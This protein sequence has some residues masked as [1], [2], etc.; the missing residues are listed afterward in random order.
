MTSPHRTPKRGGTLFLTIIGASLLLG[1]LMSA[2]FSTAKLSSQYA[3]TGS[4]EIEARYAA[5]AAIQRAFGELARDPDWRSG[6]TARTKLVQNPELTYTLEVR[7]N[8]FGTPL[9]ENE[10][11]LYAQGYSLDAIEPVPLAALAGTAVRP[12]G[13]FGEA[14]FGFAGLTMK[15]DSVS[16]AFDSRIG[17]HWYNPGEDDDDR[18]TLVADAGHVG[19]AKLV[20]L[21]DSKVEGDIVLPDPSSFQL[22]ST[23]YSG[24]AEVVLSGSGEF[25]GEEQRPKRRRE[26]PKTVSPYPEHTATTSV[27]DI[28]A[29]DVEEGHHTLAPGPYNRLEVRQ[30]QTLRLTSGAYFFHELDLRGA[31]LVLDRSSGPV[32]VFI[33]ETAS[34]VDSTVNRSEVDEDNENPKPADFQ[35]LFTD[36]EEDPTTGTSGSKAAIAGSYFNGVISGKGLQLDVKQSDLF[37][38][39]VGK[40]VTLEASKLHYDQAT[41]DINLSNHAQWRLRDLVTVPTGK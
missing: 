21:H 36:L 14:G 26:I 23:T 9:A 5:H 6:W 31:T 34:I 19:S 17:D 30:D 35:L 25:T 12:G 41:E 20:E 32:K 18:K 10:V 29:L 8:A 38:A 2:L 3:L 11:F 39:V 27:L 40:T 4:G 16:D 37:G 1:V 24:E 13:K 33:G 7:N 22:D 28:E 15:A